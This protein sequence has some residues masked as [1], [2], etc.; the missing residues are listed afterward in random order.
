MSYEGIIGGTKDAD[1]LNLEGILNTK[2]QRL[3]K[4]KDDEKNPRFK[5]NLEPIQKQITILTNEVAILDRTI[6]IY[7]ATYEKP[8]HTEKAEQL[9]ELWK[10]LEG[11]FQSDKM[12]N[13]L[14]Y[15]WSQ[16]QHDADLKQKDSKE[17]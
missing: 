2:N 1:K 10:E 6:K 5:N 17:Q 15:L 16:L 14:N 8:L 3:L 12:K 11:T 4:A 9:K 7:D 13:L